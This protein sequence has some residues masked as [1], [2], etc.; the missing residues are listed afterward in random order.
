M[1]P[2]GPL[3]LWIDVCVPWGDLQRVV[4]A[5]VPGGDPVP[6]AAA[7]PAKVGN[8]AYDDSVEVNRA[9]ELRATGAAKS[10]REAAKIAVSESLQLVGG[11]RGASPDAWEDRIRTKARKSS[12]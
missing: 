5:A 6:V 7:V 12:S 3:S 9:K 4:E 11:I 8:A 2:D 1:A 10:W